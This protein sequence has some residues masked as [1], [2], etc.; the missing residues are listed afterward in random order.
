[1]GGTDCEKK[2]LR[3]IVENLVYPVTIDVLHTVSN[4]T[5]HDS[6]IKVHKY[7]KIQAIVDL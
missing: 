3:V 5:C 2:V 7:I 4:K 6:M 1:M